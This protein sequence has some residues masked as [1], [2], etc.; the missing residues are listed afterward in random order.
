MQHSIKSLETYLRETLHAPVRLERWRQAATLPAY[1]T[2]QYDFF[3]GTVGDVHILFLHSAEEPVPSAAKKHERTLQQ[4]WTGPVAFVFDRIA[5]RTRQRMVSEGLSFVVPDNQIYL[6]ALGVNLRERYRTRVQTTDRLRPSAQ[7]LF[8]H[9]LANHSPGSNTPSGLARRLGY[10][11]MAMGQA[12]NQLEDAKL[13]NVHKEGRERRF[14]LAGEPADLW[15]QAQPL[16]ASPISRRRYLSG[17]TPSAH[18]GL[19]AAG[20]SALAT[21]SALAGPAVP[22]VA[23]DRVKA[24]S[25]QDVRGVQELPAA[26]D[27]ELEVEVWSYEPG[28]LSEGAAVDRLSLYLSLRDDTDERVQSALDEMMRGVTW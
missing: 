24:K 14:E 27:A 6:P 8:L 12:L 1:L 10:T 28:L 16:L 4:S 5:P 7:V 20:L 21:Y 9:V 22:V 13:V 18:K 19:A 15:H 26:D 2:G 17:V 11:P 3:D 23:L 25:L